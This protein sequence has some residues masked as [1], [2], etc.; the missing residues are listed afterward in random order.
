MD[1]PEVVI[2]NLGQSHG[3]FLRLSEFLF[4]RVAHEI[5]EAIVSKI[6]MLCVVLFKLKPFIID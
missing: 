2:L 6:K 4:R 5:K 3:F 1:L